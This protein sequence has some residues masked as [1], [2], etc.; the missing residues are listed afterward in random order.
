MQPGKLQTGDVE[1][2]PLF[3]SSL[4]NRACLEEMPTLPNA[5][6]LRRLGGIRSTMRLSGLVFERVGHGPACFGHAYAFCGHARFAPPR[7]V[8]CASP[9]MRRFRRFAPSC[10]VRL[11]LSICLLTLWLSGL[12]GLYAQRFPSETQSLEKSSGSDHLL[13]LVDAPLPRCYSCTLQAES[14]EYKPQDGQ[15]G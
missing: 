2:F 15:D 1:P 14:V 10:L 6:E 5:S 8:S 3:L 12:V 9:S 11:L 7:T 4:M 13:N